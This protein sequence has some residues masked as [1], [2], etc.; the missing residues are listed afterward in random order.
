MAVANAGTNYGEADD[1]LAAV[2]DEMFEKYPE[3]K[4]WEND[5][6]V[7]CLTTAICG[8]ETGAVC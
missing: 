6:Y 2:F 3:I 1:E 8:Y 4:T 7:L 5:T